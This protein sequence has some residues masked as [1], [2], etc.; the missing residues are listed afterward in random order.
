MGIKDAVAIAIEEQRGKNKEIHRGHNDV[1]VAEL[2][3]ARD[4]YDSESS[5]HACGRSADKDNRNLC[6]IARIAPAAP[7]ADQYSDEGQADRCRR[8][9]LNGVSAIDPQMILIAEGHCDSINAL[10][11]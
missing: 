6:R 8:C 1:G 11:R 10:I 5:E 3:C 9:D 4:V 2:A 7:V